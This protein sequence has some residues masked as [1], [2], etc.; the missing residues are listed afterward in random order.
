MVYSSLPKRRVAQKSMMGGNV[1]KLRNP[2]QYF[3]RPLHLH[4]R[5]RNKDQ[6]INANV[7][8]EDIFNEVEGIVVL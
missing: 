7:I 2:E 3:L 5:W 1:S 4:L 6:L 8:R